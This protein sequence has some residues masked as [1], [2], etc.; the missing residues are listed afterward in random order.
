MVR[1]IP[2]MEIARLVTNVISSIEYRAKS[3]RF[4]CPSSARRW[5]TNPMPHYGGGVKDEKL[6]KFV[7]ISLGRDKV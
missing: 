5:Q 1:T 6:N 2:A 3:C 4:P 7:S